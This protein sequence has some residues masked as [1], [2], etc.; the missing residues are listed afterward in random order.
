MGNDIKYSIPILVVGLGSGLPIILLEVLGF[1]VSL[2]VDG[3]Y[4]SLLIMFGFSLYYWGKKFAP[5]KL[6]H[7]V[8]SA[9]IWSNKSL[10]RISIF[11]FFTSFILGLLSAFAIAIANNLVGWLKITLELLFCAVSGYA[12]LGVLIFDRMDDNAGF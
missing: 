1:G 12:I 6:R 9:Y 3:V 2:D 4:A 10:G 11:L 8:V 5:L 7:M